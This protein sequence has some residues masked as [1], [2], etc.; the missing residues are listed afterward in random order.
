MGDVIL[1]TGAGKP[2]GIGF[3][4]ARQL[5][6]A[7]GSVILTARRGAD[8]DARATELRGLGHDVAGLELDV[9]DDGSIDAV[10]NAV[11]AR[12]G[13][14]D[15]LINNAAATGVYGETIAVADLDTARA[16][17]EATLFGAWRVTQ[18][19]LPLLNHSDVAR[20]VNVSSGAG[21]HADPAFGL[22]TGNGM[23]A[24]YGIAKAALNALTS[25]LAV[26]NP[27][28]RVNAVCPGFTATFEGGEAM[29]A[30][31]VAEGAAGV[32]WAARLPKDGPTGG[33]FRDG[34]PLGW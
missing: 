14:L 9:T 12:H 16:T 6:Q 27:G 26:E 32:V 34:Q 25:R 13:R 5:A 11:R 8:A 17:L 2:T 23:G 22:T 30:R 15:V 4:A 24:A 3:E 28:M 18:A 21:S 20:I 10:A 31:P 33:F 1:I 19:M 29:G 7:G